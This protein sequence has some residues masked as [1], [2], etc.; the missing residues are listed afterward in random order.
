MILSMR[1]ARGTL[2]AL[3]CLATLG[4]SQDDGLLETAPTNITEVAVEGGNVRV[5][6]LGGGFVMGSQDLVNGD[7]YLARYDAS[8]ELMWSLNFAPSQPLAIRVLGEQII[9]LADESVFVFDPAGNQTAS[10]AVPNA[11][12]LAVG[13]GRLVVLTDDAVLEFDTE[14]T[15][16]ASHPVDPAMTSGWSLE[17]SAA[18]YCPTGFA[19]D[20]N[21]TTCF[22]WEGVATQVALVQPGT[23]SSVER[24]F[25]VLSDSGVVS[26][27]A[28]SDALHAYSV[29]LDTGYFAGEY[30]FPYNNDGYVSRLFLGP[31]DRLMWLEI[32]DWCTD[33]CY[34]GFRVGLLDEDRSAMKWRSELFEVPGV[35]GN[36]WTAT[37]DGER[38]YVASN[39]AVWIVTSD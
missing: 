32:G 19:S 2:L 25:A 33:N 36:D 1:H 34:L 9:A 6:G 31:D 7:G 24:D 23:A 18:G 37:T 39:R 10:W 11:R 12:D 30:E 35:V 4:C 5:A 22:S 28:V 13:G 16:V 14:G 20:Q 38:I 15:M 3:S 26:A 8:S 27:L 29:D 21:L 17:A